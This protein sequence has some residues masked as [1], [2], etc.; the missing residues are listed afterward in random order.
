MILVTGGTGLLGSHLLFQLTEKKTSV[1]AIYRDG[2]RIE[3]IRKLF[4]Y[5]NPSAGNEQFDRIQW[6]AADILDITSL[7]EAFEGI[8]HV[9][10]CAGFVSFN[11][12]H[13]DKLIKVNREGTENVVNVCLKHAVKKLCHV[14][15]TSALG[16][17]GAAVINEEVKWKQSPETS[18]Y[19]I[20]KYSAEKEIWRGVE[21]GLDSVIVNPALIFGAGDWNE[22]SLAIFRT[23]QKGLRFYTPGSNAIVDARDTA[24]IMIQLMESEIV[25]ERFLCFG[26]NISFKDLTSVIAVKLGKKPPSINTPKWLMG[27]AWRI[28]WL[29]ARL[30][31][32][33]PVVTKASAQNAFSKTIYDNSKVRSALNFKFRSVEDTIENTIR[34]KMS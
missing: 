12:R 33:Y 6:V 23:V 14:S 13:F 30:R 24:A 1:R 10:H 21:E 2:K 4:N 3:K 31:G 17:E 8:T 7:E 29:T 16:S 26:E 5:Y 22:S 32:K 20:S 25:N 15:S 27:L 28:S 19:S 11:K 18:G 9:Y 34:G